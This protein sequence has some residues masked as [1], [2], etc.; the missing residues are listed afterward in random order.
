MK[1]TLM[2][3]LV[4]ATVACA[5][6]Y[7]WVNF[8]GLPGT[9]G[10]VDGG[11]GTSR[12]NGTYGADCD[13]SGNI[14]IADRGNSKIKKITSAG[15][16]STLSA[17]G[18]NLPTH[19]VV[20]KS[21]GNLYVADL[22]NGQIKKIVSPYTSATTIATISAIGLGESAQAKAE[23][24]IQAAL[25]AGEEIRQSALAK[26]EQIAQQELQSLEWAA[27][28]LRGRRK[29]D[30]QKIR[31]AARLRRET[32]MTLEWIANRL[33]MRAATHVASLLHRQSQKAQNR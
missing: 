30:P 13:N 33:G 14:Y 15:V 5:Q 1:H 18:F 12:L 23:R 3:L 16:V 19:V 21:N 24:L 10:D 11:T 6:S 27:E 31:I 29:S 26:A 25:H 7:S 32:T 2:I 8:A 28:A 17:S 4:S 20:N 9:P 22:G